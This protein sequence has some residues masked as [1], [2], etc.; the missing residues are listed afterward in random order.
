MMRKSFFAF[1]LSAGALAGPV[2]VVAPPTTTAPAALSGAADENADSPAAQL[3]RRIE[4]LGQAVPST[5]PY[6]T[7]FAANRRRLRVLLREAELYLTLYPGGARRDEVI[8]LELSGLYELAALRGEAPTALR[9]RVA[10]LLANPPS[11]TVLHEAAYWKLVCERSGC[12]VPTGTQ[13]AVG[14]RRDMAAW[15]AACEAYIKAYPTSRYVPRLVTLCF[16]D[17]I[18]RGDWQKMQAALEHMR[19]YFPDH[20]ATE[21]LA[22]KWR[23]VSALGEPVQIQLELVNGEVFDSKSVRGRPLLVVVWA[24]YDDSSR[25]CL[26]AIAAYR[27]VHEELAVV[28]VALDGEPKLALRAADELGIDWPLACDRLGWGGRFVRTWAIK[29]LPTVLAVDKEGRLAGI[30]SEHSWKERVRRLLERG[31]E[32]P[33]GDSERATG[34]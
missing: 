10:E 5:Q 24:A 28:G 25:R 16:E 19:T 18:A 30:A 1:V 3:W 27:K 7:W 22:A 17:A 20:P 26:R 15:Q 32:V 14:G 4:K 34:P 21:R 8:R 31:A 29:R 2:G 33:R 23:R 6:E 12:V 9:K 11:D 13:P